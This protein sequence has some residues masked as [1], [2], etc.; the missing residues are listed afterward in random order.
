MGGGK[1]AELLHKQA[2]SRK[3]KA[4]VAAQQSREKDAPFFFLLLLLLA[5]EEPGSLGG[6]KRCREKDC[7][8]G[9]ATV[10]SS[11]HGHPSKR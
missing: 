3:S 9:R 5:C 11:L 8:R 4:A 10:A 6:V 7:G 1:G 2:G